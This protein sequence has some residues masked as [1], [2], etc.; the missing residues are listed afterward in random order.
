MTDEV[1]AGVQ[2]HEVPLVSVVVIGRNEGQRLQRCLDSIAAMS[3]RGFEVEVIYVD[4]DS[5][6][7]SVALAEAANARTIALKPARPSAALG[8][9]AGWRISKGSFVLF[10]DGDTILH[11]EFVA[12]SLTDLSR[13][14]IGIVWGNLRE[15]YPDR[16]LYI[17]VLDLD[18]I[19]PPGYTPFCGGNALY[20]R[21]ILEATNGF[22]DTLV[23]GEEPELCQRI[24]ALG[25]R[26]LHADRPM[27]G[28]DLA[29][30]RWKQYWKRCTRGGHAYA[31]VSE[32]FRGTAQPFW[33]GEARRNRNR[34]ML[35][36][37]C[38][39]TGVGG[40]IVLRSLIP[41]GLFCLF[42]AMLSLRSAWKARWKT[43]DLFA[44]AMYGV[45][46]H[47]QQVPVYMGQLQYQRS[48]KK[49][50][51]RSLFEYK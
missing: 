47:L 12:D 39:V 5:T 36:L 49:G 1:G 31:E 42:I 15:L 37:A 25:F 27:A 13:D 16:S 28:H 19:Y 11:P 43:N 29:I 41:V 10:L 30:T 38:F 2:T 35:L 51:R 45:H 50:V 7:G 44:L 33:D 34:F 8:R 3:R 48:R 24:T 20:R 9:N 14:N 6:D 21:S 46:S 40:S 17:R 22:D 23:A 18:W 26:I 32:R 4:S